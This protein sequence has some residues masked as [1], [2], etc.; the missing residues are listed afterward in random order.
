MVQSGWRSQNT[1]GQHY[2]DRESNALN[3]AGEQKLYWIVTQAP[4]QFRTVYVTQALEAEASERRIDSVQQT[5]VKLLPDQP[6]PAVLPTT[7]E[8]RGWSADYIDAIDRK[9][10]STI[11][12]PRLPAFRPAGAV[13]GG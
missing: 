3:E 8:P 4:E 11:P 2:F 7:N 12:P 6:L 13:E 9:Q 1:L 5:L 10:Q